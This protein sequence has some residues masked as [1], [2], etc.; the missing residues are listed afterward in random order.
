MWTNISGWFSNLASSAFNWGANIIQGII[1]GIGSM[2]SAL[3][4]AASGAAD[5]VAQ[6]LGFHSPAKQGPGKELDIWGPNL[7]KGFA[8][9]IDRAGAMLQASVQHLMTIGTYPIRPSV[10]GVAAS[11]A[12]SIVAASGSSGD[13]TTII[14]LDSMQ[15]A[16]IVQKATDRKV[17]LKL[18]A[19][20]RSI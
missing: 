15:L 12:A 17:R 9:G 19:K 20:G 1:N 5:T 3:G 6:Y 7:V 16:E 10:L 8:Q 4:S 13:H 11:S 14:E 18:S 2:F